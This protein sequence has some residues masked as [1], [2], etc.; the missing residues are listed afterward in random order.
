MSFTDVVPVLGASGDLLAT[1]VFTK[2][3]AP[4]HFRVHVGPTKLSSSLTVAIKGTRGTMVT[5]GVRQKGK[6]HTFWRG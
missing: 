1:G 6:R 4:M 5:T 3:D 2:A